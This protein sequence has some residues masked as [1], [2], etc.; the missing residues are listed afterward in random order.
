MT[1]LTDRYVWAVLRSLPNGQRRAGARDRA[2]IA[3]AIEARGAVGIPAPDAERAALVELGDPDAL[4]ARYMDR[5]LA[6]I[7]PRLYPE[8][9]PA[10]HAAAADRGAARHGGHGGH[11]GG[12]RPVALGAGGHR[13]HRRA[14]RGH[15]A[16]LVHAGLRA[17]RAC[18]RHDD[19]RPWTPERL[20]NCP[21]RRGRASPRPSRRSWRSPSASSSSASS[22]WPSPS[23]S[24]DG[25]SGSSTPT[26]GRFWLPYFALLLVI[27]A[28]FAVV[29]WR[30]GGYTWTLATVN[31]VT[32]LRVPA[33]RAQAAR[34]RRGVRPRLAAAVGEGGALERVR[35]ARRHPRGAARDLR[36]LDIVEGY[37][38]AAQRG[39]GLATA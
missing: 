11:G 27:E 5:P 12:G 15:P 10:A 39:D 24:A 4:A 25:S 37:R 32:G 31:V 7:R 3:D 18:W 20:P 8:V 28:I 22:R 26:S 1:T 14:E 21:P 23:S 2:L 33:A 34:G 9:A 36:A 38:K 29:L 17:H 30:A 35:A 19:G 13:H 6:L 16:L